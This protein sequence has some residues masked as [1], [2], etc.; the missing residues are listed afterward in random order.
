MEIIPD[1]AIFTISTPVNELGGCL[2]AGLV[3]SICGRYL[4]CLTRGLGENG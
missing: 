2:H 3:L 1:T 4:R